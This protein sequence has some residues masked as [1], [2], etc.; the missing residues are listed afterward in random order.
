MLPDENK[1]VVPYQRGSLILG[2]IMC[3]SD[4]FFFAKMVHFK[5]GVGAHCKCN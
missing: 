1:L 4:L 2:V 3:N 5:D